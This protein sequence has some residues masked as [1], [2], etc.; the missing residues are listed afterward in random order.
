MP[1]SAVIVS[2]QEF[3]M[4]QFLKLNGAL[5]RALSIVASVGIIVTGVTFAALQSQQAVLSGNTIQ[6]ATASLL[7]GT[8]T[9]TSTAYS[10]SHSGFSFNDIVPGAAAQPAGGNVFYLKNTGT[11]T[12]SV[13]LNVNGTPTNPSNVDLGKVKITVVRTDTN[14]SQTTTLQALIDSTPA[15]GLTLTDTL[16][17]SATGTQYTMT[18]SMTADAFNG[19]SATIG[20]I[21]FSFSGTGV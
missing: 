4:L 17:P 7:I 15:G 18:V 11:A 12:L 10:S 6:S 5:A 8:A 3:S 19:S 20:A 1:S 14:T 21:D 9:A 2:K 16:A 13:K